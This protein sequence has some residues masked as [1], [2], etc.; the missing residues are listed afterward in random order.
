LN[1]GTTN[2]LHS[3]RFINDTTG[4][5]VSDSGTILKTTDGGS[6]WTAH[7]VPVSMF[8]TSVYF[9]DADTGY[10]AGASGAI[11]K[12]TN[13]GTNWMVQNSGTSQNLS[14]VYF[15]APTQGFAVGD[16]GTILG[17]TTGTMGI[18][19]KQPLM[20]NSVQIYPNPTFS[21]ITVVISETPATGQ[22]S[23]LNLNGEELLR[24]NTITSKNIVDVSSLASGVYLVKLTNERTVH[25]GKFI[26]N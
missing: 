8:L 12:T 11:L 10:A 21:K 9:I 19:N 5:V 15:S 14:S 16:S 2:P 4:F 22:L 26:K 18:G 24:Q 7:N 3:V 13:G 25:V 23:I 17:T 20:S 6:T 1:S